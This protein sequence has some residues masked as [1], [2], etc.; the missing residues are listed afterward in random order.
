MATFLSRYGKFITAI[1]GAVTEGINL[2]VVPHSAQN[3]VTIGVSI[4]TALG[5]YAVPNAPVPSVAATVTQTAAAVAD[6]ASVL[7]T[8]ATLLD[9]LG[10]Q[11]ASL[12]PAEP[13][14]PP[15]PVAA[16]SP[17]PPAPEPVIPDPVVPVDPIAALEALAA[18]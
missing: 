17:E 3:Y 7:A 2:G 12:S 9:T 11:V 4:L 16:L 10:A 1:L 13:V 18:S 8:H 14:A 6:H 5:V 15:E